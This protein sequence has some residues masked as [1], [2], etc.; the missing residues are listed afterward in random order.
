MHSYLC[1]IL[2][3]DSN[4]L[5]VGRYIDESN[6]LPSTR[7]EVCF[8]TVNEE[9]NNFIVSCD[10]ELACF[11]KTYV[12]SVKCLALSSLGTFGQSM[13]F[14]QTTCTQSSS[15]NRALTTFF[16]LL[17]VA[18][19]P[20]WTRA[21]LLRVFATSVVTSKTNRGHVHKYEIQSYWDI[22]RTFCQRQQSAVTNSKKTTEEQLTFVLTNR[23]DASGNTPGGWLARICG[24]LCFDG[25]RNVDLGGDSAGNTC[26]K[27]NRASQYSNEHDTTRLGQIPKKFHWRD[28][29][30]IMIGD[31]R[32]PKVTK[33]PLSRVIPKRAISYRA[34]PRSKTGDDFH[35][36]NPIALP[37]N[38][39]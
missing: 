26:S 27:E 22:P 14:H 35:Q 21:S 31:C 30:M 9:L 33:F 19:R 12:D 24:C 37:H 16:Y 13:Q 4:N 3:F 38:L 11:C 34:L 23:F 18:V 6:W 7:R 10:G 15:I 36:L 1:R 17:N 5:C 39:N 8:D 2:G 25:L 29:L 32:N 28:A 20:K